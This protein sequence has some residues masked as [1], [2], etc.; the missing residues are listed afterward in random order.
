[1]YVVMILFI[2]HSLSKQL[3]VNNKPTVSYKCEYIFT[4]TLIMQALMIISDIFVC[5]L[6]DLDM[7]KD[8]DVLIAEER[9]EIIDKYDKVR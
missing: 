7:K 6:P 9:A 5:F 2:C 4:L 1:M 8:I 3:S